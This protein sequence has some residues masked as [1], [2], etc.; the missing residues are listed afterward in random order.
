[1]TDVKVNLISDVHDEHLFEE[2]A[3]LH[4]DRVPGGFLT[5]FGERFLQDLYRAIVVTAE[6]GVFYAEN[7]GGIVGFIAVTTNAKKVYANFVLRFGWKYLFELIQQLSLSRLA[8]IAELAL[9][10]IRRLA[11]DSPERSARAE[12]LNFCVAR[13]VARSGVGTLLFRKMESHYLSVGEEKLFIVTG[14][15]QVEA[16]RF[17]ENLGAT[18][19]GS[20]E[21]HRGTESVRY[22]YSFGSSF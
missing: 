20:I 13:N 8:R 1:M 3:K 11:G 22:L 15:Q 18:R 12:I 4:V 7:D 10:P 5:S 6:G 9:Y 14:A 17:Y 2:I 16:Q 21:I 19:L